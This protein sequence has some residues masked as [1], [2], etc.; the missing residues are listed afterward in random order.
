MS[1]NSNI[2]K[3]KLTIITLLKAFIKDAF[4][5]FG[6]DFVKENI[7]KKT[8]YY[9][10]NYKYIDKIIDEIREDIIDNVNVSTYSHLIGKNSL[11]EQA[12]KLANNKK[13][14]TLRKVKE[15]IYHYMKVFR[16]RNPKRY[17]FIKMK[18]F[19]KATPLDIEKVLK[20]NTKQQKDISD[21]IVSFF[22]RQFKK[23]GIGG[24]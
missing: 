4:F 5:F 19:D 10:Y 3:N 8:E 9:L 15:I 17:N 16:Q 6:R 13:I 20:Y 24:M 14:Y 2:T 1:T 21:M 22:Y 11:E 18:Y 7:Y 12:I 23:N